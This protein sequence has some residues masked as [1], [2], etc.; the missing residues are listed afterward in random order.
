M[1]HPR[2]LRLLRAALVV[3]GVAAGLLVGEGAARSV[4]TSLELENFNL[5]G[6]GNAT[7]CVQPSVTRGYEPIP[8]SCGVNADGA[9][10]YEQA[11]R[12][13][14]V[15]VMV[16]GDSITTQTTWP[17]SLTQGLATR[18]D[19][20]VELHTYGVPGYNTCQ[21]LT[22]YLEK[23]QGVAPDVVLLQACMNDARG[24]P[25]L[26]RDGGM[27]RVHRQGEV[28][29][30]PAIFL[31]SRLLTL[32]MSTLAPTSAGVSEAEAARGCLAHLRDDVDARGVPLFTTLFPLFYARDVAPPDQM[33]DEDVMRTLLR[34][35]GAAFL[36]LRPVYE[37]AGPMA[38]HRD[39]PADS[40]HPSAAGQRE[41]AWALAEWM[42]AR[43]PSVR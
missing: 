12:G 15:R 6:G 43:P 21:E 16:V 39:S 22:M 40:I 17:A 3:C 36:D 27:V 23:V 33:A 35:S 34:A 9:R 26:T 37:A 28:T 32:A 38:D 2:R 11:G 24:S 13:P 1:R 30:F 10:V 19:R 29:T 18:W 25:V 8:G 41:A 42:G 5:A 14:P 31:W 20:A 4:H 7:G